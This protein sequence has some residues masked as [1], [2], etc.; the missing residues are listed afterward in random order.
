MM[1]FYLNKKEQSYNLGL[2]IRTSKD[3]K[4]NAQ[5]SPTNNFIPITTSFLYE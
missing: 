1:P 2:C 5:T 3:I 4:Y